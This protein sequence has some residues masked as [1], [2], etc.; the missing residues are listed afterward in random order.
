MWPTGLAAHGPV[1]EPMSPALVGE[2]FTTEPP[3]KPLIVAFLYMAFIIL[4]RFLSILSLLIFFFFFDHER[5]LRSESEV[6]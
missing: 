3:G 4:R 6:A 2:F 5:A 1:I